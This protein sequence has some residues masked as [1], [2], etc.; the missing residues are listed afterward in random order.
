MT[1]EVLEVRHSKLNMASYGSGSAARE[2]VNMAFTG[3]VFFYYEGVVGLETWIIFL[4]TFLFALY[5][6]VNDPLIGYLT[7]RPFKFTKKRGRR[8]PWLL[9]GGIPYIL[10]ELIEYKSNK[11]N[12]S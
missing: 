10:L 4:A 7:N 12:V 2:F 8:F 6:M 3:T 9:L 5:N 1:E 11:Q